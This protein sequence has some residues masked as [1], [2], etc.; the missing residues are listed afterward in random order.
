MQGTSGT[1]AQRLVAQYLDDYILEHNASPAP[2][3]V[4][5]S[6]LDYC[7]FRVGQFQFAIASAAITDEWVDSTRVVTIGGW[8]LVPPRYR[9]QSAE[10]PHTRAMDSVMLKG[11]RV[12]L[13]GIL[14]VGELRI[15][16]AAVIARGMRTDAPWIAGSLRV[17]PSFVLDP[18]ALQLHFMRR[19]S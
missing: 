16:D 13:T 3:P 17:P 9:T 7:R 10:Q 11:G 2:L 6:A 5:A 1:R 18:D 19:F 8:S 12:A 4:P 15:T 14:R